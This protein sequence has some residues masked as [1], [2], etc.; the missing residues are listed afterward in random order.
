MI[1]RKSAETGCAF[2]ERVNEYVPAS[3]KLWALVFKSIAAGHYDDMHSE[4]EAVDVE[5]VD[6]VSFNS[7]IYQLY[8]ETCLDAKTDLPSKFRCLYREERDEILFAIKRVTE[9][10]L[11]GYNEAKTRF[12]ADC[13]E[14]DYFNEVIKNCEL[15][16]K[17]CQQDWEEDEQ[18]YHATSEYFNTD[19]LK[20]LHELVNGVCIEEIDFKTFNHVMNCDGEYYYTRYDEIETYE[21]NGEV[22]HIPQGNWEEV[23]EDY[24]DSKIVPISG[25]AMAMYAL[26]LILIS[27]RHNYNEEPSIYNGEVVYPETWEQQFKS[28]IDWKKNEFDLE[29]DSWKT[30]YIVDNPEPPTYDIEQKASDWLGMLCGRRVFRGVF[31]S[32]NFEEIIVPRD[33]FPIGFEQYQFIHDNPDRLNELYGLLVEETE[34]LYTNIQKIADCFDNKYRAESM[35][36]YASWRSVEKQKNNTRIH[37]IYSSLDSIHPETIQRILFERSGF[38]YDNL[39]NL[40]IIYSEIVEDYIKCCIVQDE[41]LKVEIKRA[42]VDSSM[43][44]TESKLASERGE[45]DDARY[46]AIRRLQKA[47]IIDKDCNVLPK[48]EGG[49]Y[50]KTTELTNFLVRNELV[51]PKDGWTGMLSMLKSLKV[52]GDKKTLSGHLRDEYYRYDLHKHLGWCSKQLSWSA[53]IDAFYLQGEK[54]GEASLHHYFTSNN[55]ERERIITYMLKKYDKP[56]GETAHTTI[57]KSK[58]EDD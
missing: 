35:Q 16:I 47:N 42:I 26:V 11:D 18:A 29:E 36:E 58:I 28:R 46:S 8:Q 53:F 44:E 32:A 2:T 6:D 15:I 31:T 27:N 49:K 43:R 48:K 12:P 13:P 50:F 55:D 45:H 51:V 34:F 9:D 38:A 54:L 52:D 30:A 10:I 25:F 21:Y 1:S 7:S 5:L 33:S 41:R 17:L 3:W 19:H 14:L 37:L 23:W 57:R 39:T 20:S 56:M 40:P 24:S 22:Y 4:L